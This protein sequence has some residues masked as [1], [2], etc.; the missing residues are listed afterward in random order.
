MPAIAIILLVAGAWFFA[1]AL[2][3]YQGY[4]WADQSCASIPYFCDSPELVLGG[5]IIAALI[6]LG[7]RMMSS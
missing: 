2:F 5:C 6:L 3:Q 4:G 7:M 1:A